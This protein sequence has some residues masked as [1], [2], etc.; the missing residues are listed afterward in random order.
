[1][2]RLVDVWA[3]GARGGVVV[4][5]ERVCGGCVLFCEAITKVWGEMGAVGELGVF[6]A[7]GGGVVF[8][9]GDGVD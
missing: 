3:V 4:V 1:M 6:G 5:V 8:E 9:A 7:V 2:G